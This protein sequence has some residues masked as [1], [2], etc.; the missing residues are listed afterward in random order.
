MISRAVLCVLALLG[1]GAFVA[2]AQING[3]LIPDGKPLRDAI[4]S[5]LGTKLSP[6]ARF[7]V[8][9][10]DLDG[11]GR[12]EAIAYLIDSNRCGSGGCSVFILA[13]HQKRWDVIDRIGPAQLP[14]YRLGRGADGWAE[15]GITVSGGGVAQEVMAVPHSSSG[16]ADNPTVAPSRPVDPA[17]TEIII[18]EPKE[19][20]RGLE[21]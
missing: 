8:G 1:C 5:S 14:V 20:L 18:R 17:G 10:N 21:E 3:M 13:Q 7:I 19:G 12:N 6:G 11:D 15:L 16:Y 4:V 2:P 9:W